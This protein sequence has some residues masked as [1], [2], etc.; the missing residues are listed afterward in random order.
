[1]KRCSAARLYAFLCVAVAMT[2]CAA[3]AEAQ[4]QPRPLSDPAT[5]EDY[6]I[7]GAIDLW[8]PSTNIRVASEAFGIPG[9]IIDFRND[10][11]LENKWHPAFRL[12]VRPARR[13]KFRFQFIPVHYESEA[14]LR[15]T[16]IFNGQRY[17]IGVPVESIVNWNAYRFA[18]EFDFVSN[19]RG[20]GGVVVEAKYTDATVDLSTPLLLEFARA[21]APVPA[22]GGIG[23]IYVVPN[24]SITGEF[25]LFRLPEELIEDSSG[26][27]TD[28]D[29]Y[30]T[31]N[32][33]N[34]IGVQ[35]GYRSLDAFYSIDEDEGDL[36][37]RGL[38]FGFVARY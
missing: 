28:F 2:V 34:H 14:I 27:Y 15:R 17:D 5:G 24:I 38:Y 21:R 33:T 31:V 6:H 35:F 20:F 9:T 29:L 19:D 37:L 8:F 16:I 32:F 7:E 12:V 36:E 25:S 11:G 22:I 26:H 13:H 10:L 30:G 23:R 4:F 3:P 1:M 18:Y